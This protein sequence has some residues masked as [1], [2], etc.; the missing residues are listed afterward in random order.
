MNSNC[1]INSCVVEVINLNLNLL[2][3][4]ILFIESKR[5]KLVS[6]KFIVSHPTVKP[7]SSCQLISGYS[8]YE[9][10]T[11]GIHLKTK[12]RYQFSHEA[13]KAARMTSSGILKVRNN[14]NGR[15]IW[16]IW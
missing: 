1:E 3:L 12:N 2:I 8:Q 10:G 4:K 9:K 5:V 11:K 6:F 13:V 7:L 15:R 14:S 16:A